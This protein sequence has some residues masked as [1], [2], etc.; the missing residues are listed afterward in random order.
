MASRAAKSKDIILP[1]EALATWKN[2]HPESED[3]LVS[4]T[5]FSRL[6]CSFE[7]VGQVVVRLKD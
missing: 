3:L 2:S 1:L 6:P 4:G 7:W 5:D